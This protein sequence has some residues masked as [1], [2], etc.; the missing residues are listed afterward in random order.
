[1]SLTAGN[2]RIYQGYRE[3]DSILGIGSLVSRL[4]QALVDRLNAMRRMLLEALIN[5]TEADSYGDLLAAELLEN[6][7]AER[8]SLDLP[9]PS[10][11][12]AGVHC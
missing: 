1:M 9:R 4:P 5:S 6:V 12:T 7:T 10:S 8:S 2:L 11:Q 3:L